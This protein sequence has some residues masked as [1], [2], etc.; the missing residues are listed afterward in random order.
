MEQ[1]S[2]CYFCGD[3]PDA[4]LEEHPAV[5][6]SLRPPGE[7]E[8]T[9]VL[10]PTCRRKLDAVL[11]T[12]VA[13]VE[14]GS[15]TADADAST[16]ASTA[17]GTEDD[18]GDVE[19]TLGDDGD[20]LRPIGDGETDASGDSDGAS[21]AAAGDAA[22]SDE[23]VGKVRTDDAPEGVGSEPADAS[24]ADDG[25]S[26]GPDADGGSA[27][28]HGDAGARGQGDKSPSDDGDESGSEDEDATGGRERAEESDDADD[29]DAP[30]VTLTRLENTKVMRL[31]RNREF[32]VDREDFVTVA[33]SAYE[34]SPR[35][36]D[37][38]V[39]LAVDHDLLRE[40]G[41]QLYAGSNWN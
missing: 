37:K 13:A 36:C 6:E 7:P 40:E 33:S 30:D 31:L 2:S 20:L 38:V 16:A 10:C 5:P 19:S 39:Q 26:A 4:S 18:P 34:V 35:H 8:T 27:D 14:S 21:D 23:D 11:E 22:R 12:V 9:V 32:P 28:D 41:G 3:A 15:G 29:A 17:P 24:G 1:L 25:G